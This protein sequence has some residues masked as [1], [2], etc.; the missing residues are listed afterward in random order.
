M[1][2]ETAVA[3]P[4]RHMGQVGGGALGQDLDSPIPTPALAEQRVE[5]AAERFVDHRELEADTGHGAEVRAQRGGRALGRDPTAIE[6]RNRQQRRIGERWSTVLAGRRNRARV[7]VLQLRIECQVQRHPGGKAAT[8]ERTVDA[9]GTAEGIIHTGDLA[10]I[11]LA[12]ARLKLAE[13]V[14]SHGRDQSE[15]PHRREEAA[16]P[17]QLEGRER[18]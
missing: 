4:G 5:E 1:E 13:R 8:N 17:H 12:V 2:L 10:A 18:G 11:D 16:H 3:G 15:D 7:F 6:R 9:V 14:A